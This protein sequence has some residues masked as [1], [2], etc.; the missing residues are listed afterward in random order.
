MANDDFEWDPRWNGEQPLHSNTVPK[1]A[2][3]ASRTRVVPKPGE[4]GLLQA[5]GK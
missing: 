2:F 1:L 3:D 4:A 5:P